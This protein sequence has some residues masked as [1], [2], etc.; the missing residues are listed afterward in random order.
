MK[1]SAGC[2]QSGAF[3]TRILKKVGAPGGPG[4]SG[5]FS[6]RSLVIQ[7]VGTKNV[8]WFKKN[9]LRYCWKIQKKTCKLN[10]SWDHSQELTLT[11]SSDFQAESAHWHHH[12]HS[13]YV[14]ACRIHTFVPS[15][16]TC[17]V[18]C[19]L[20][21]VWAAACSPLKSAA[22][23]NV[24]GSTLCQSVSSPPSCPHFCLL[25]FPLADIQSLLPVP[26]KWSE[27]KGSDCEQW[28]A[29]T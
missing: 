15:G 18:Q 21:A 23:C 10:V 14:A 1:S 11:F 26:P 5:S 17:P 27:I 3:A 29:G 4:R 6:R 8:G 2:C 20:T 12:N 28:R 22:D 16:G 19:V 25:L 24:S 7:W 13:G 9:N